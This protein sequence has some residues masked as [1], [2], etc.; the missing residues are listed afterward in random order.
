MMDNPQMDT[1]IGFHSYPEDL[2]DYS[3]AAREK[4]ASRCRDFVKKAQHLLDTATVP[5]FSRMSVTLF[6]KNM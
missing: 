5:I 4:S 2:N 6:N 3:L 1:S